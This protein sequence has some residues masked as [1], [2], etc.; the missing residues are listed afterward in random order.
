M[1]Q[2]EHSYGEASLKLGHTAVLSQTCTH[3]ESDDSDE[4]CQ[5]KRQLTFEYSSLHYDDERFFVP[6]HMD[7]DE[8]D[9][10]ISV[11]PHDKWNGHKLSRPA[12]RMVEE[13]ETAYQNGTHDGI[14]VNP[15]PDYGHVMVT[16]DG[17]GTLT[18]RP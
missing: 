5:H 8:L 6:D 4:R 3:S 11:P 13:I 2:H 7:E 16:L 10:T 12:K 1:Q 9:Q 17:V 14:E 15:D 18:Y